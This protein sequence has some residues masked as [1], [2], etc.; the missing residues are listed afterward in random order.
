[1][2]EIPPQP[3]PYDKYWEEI[4]N[5]RTTV[6]LDEVIRRPMI[7]TEDSTSRYRSMDCVCTVYSKSSQAS[8]LTRL[9][10]DILGSYE[11]ILEL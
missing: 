4:I 3:Q 7:T 10:M 2:V 11:V 1:M 5:S 8:S 6:A 9:M